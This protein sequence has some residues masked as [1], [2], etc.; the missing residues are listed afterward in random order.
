MPDFA[1]AIWQENL[2]ENFAK[3]IDN[4]CTNCYYNKALL[5]RPFLRAVICGAGSVKAERAALML[6]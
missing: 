3:G 4:P 2:Q 5:I 1:P 6:V